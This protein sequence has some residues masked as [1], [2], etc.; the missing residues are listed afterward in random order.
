MSDQKKIKENQLSKN[1]NESNY[2]M[3]FIHF[4]LQTIITNQ[5]EMKQALQV[6]IAENSNQIK[7][8]HEEIKNFVVDAGKQMTDVQSKIINGMSSFT[9]E[10]NKMKSDLQVIKGKD[11]IDSQKEIACMK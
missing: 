1:I 9:H 5:N 6:Q 8:N 7:Q 2:D 10:I 4:M 3:Y 11:L